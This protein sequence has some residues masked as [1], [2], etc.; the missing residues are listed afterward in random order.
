MRPRRAI[1]QTPT[2]YRIDGPGGFEHPSP[3]LIHAARDELDRVDP[4]P[5]PHT[6]GILEIRTLAGHGWT[7]CADCG[8][9]NP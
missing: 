1:T 7:M 4:L 3:T 9:P 8:Q 2:G 6:S 5:C